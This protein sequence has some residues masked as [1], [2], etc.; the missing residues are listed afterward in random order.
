MSNYT[1][2]YLIGWEKS[3]FAYS[4]YEL[5]IRSLWLIPFQDRHISSYDVAGELGIDHKTVLAH[6]K[7]AGYTKQLD[8]W[9]PHELTERNLM[10]RLLICDSLLRRNETEP[11]LKKL[12]TG[13]EEWITYDKNVRKRSVNLTKIVN[14]KK[15]RALPNSKDI[16]VKYNKK[17]I[18]ITI[19]L[20]K[21]M[22]FMKGY[23]FNLESPINFGA[24][25]NKNKK[26]QYVK[27][28]KYPSAITRNILLIF[29]PN[30][31]EKFAPI[32]FTFCNNVV[33]STKKAAEFPNDPLMYR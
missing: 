32:F 17:N 18:F 14:R 22:I 12:I 24:D 9:V 25:C 10:N 23:N 6:L 19:S 11:F 27:N 15:P 4:M 8:I 29:S 28:N 7:K 33:S 26:T 31:S 21:T 5:V 20:W 1:S 13:D 16:P 3:L 2:T 30:V